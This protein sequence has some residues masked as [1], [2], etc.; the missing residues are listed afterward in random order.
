M[1]KETVKN[2]MKNKQ[3]LIAGFIVGLVT[4]LF[5]CELFQAGTAFFAGASNIHFTLSVSGLSSE[6]HMPDELYLIIYVV[7]Y[8]SPILL[9]LVI[10][11][12]GMSIL[13]RLG[14]GFTRYAAII[15]EI[16]LI[17]FLI[18]NIFYGAIAAVLQLKSNDWINLI[19]YLNL[20]WEGGI[21]F[22]FLMILILAAYLNFTTKRIINY[23]NA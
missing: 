17:G 7:V 18:V 6:F 5:I 20:S 11:E 8:I 14:L 4:V 15:F 1:L 23:I 16:I 3:A 10:L 12:A 2:R 13:K 9:S 21:M 22:M 19:Y